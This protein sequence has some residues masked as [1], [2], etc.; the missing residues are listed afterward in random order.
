MSL[1]GDRTD[2]RALH[3]FPRSPPAQIY[4][5]SD[6]EFL[7][8]ERFPCKRHPVYCPLAT[9]RKNEKEAPAASST[10]VLPSRLISSYF[11]SVSDSVFHRERCVSP[12]LY[13]ETTG[14]DLYRERA[15]RRFRRIKCGCRGKRTTANSIY[16]NGKSCDG[17]R[18]R[19]RERENVFLSTRGPAYSNCVLRRSSPLRA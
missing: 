4:S 5:L 2:R 16:S 3:K 14:D 17:E 10:S 8:D 1:N 13:L 7:P 9:G 12:F 11:F 15:R 19:E 18:E 6:G